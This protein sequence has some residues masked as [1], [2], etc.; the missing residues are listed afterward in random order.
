MI[1]HLSFGRT[2][3]ASLVA[4]AA[5]GALLLGSLPAVAVEAGIRRHRPDRDGHADDQSPGHAGADQ[6][7]DEPGERPANHPPGRQCTC[8]P[9]GAGPS[10][11]GH[12]W[13]LPRG[14]HAD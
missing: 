10:L 6:G 14:D 7:A 3:A 2:L 5:T 1:T 4:V 9:R 13:L 8:W 12:S 11:D